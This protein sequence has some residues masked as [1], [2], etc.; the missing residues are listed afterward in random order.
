MRISIKVFYMPLRPKDHLDW[1]SL[2]R[3]TNTADKEL[4]RYSI[5]GRRLRA[6]CISVPT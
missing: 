6:F 2:G 1:M 5:Y 3:R 4:Q